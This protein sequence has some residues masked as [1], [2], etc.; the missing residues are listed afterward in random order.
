MAEY[1]RDELGVPETQTQPPPTESR[2][3]RE[4]LI[5]SRALLAS[6]HNPITVV[7]SSYQVFR[8]RSCANLRRFCAT[9]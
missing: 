6:E 1:L 8:A 2:T 7:T 5:Y 9:T 3:T 4:N